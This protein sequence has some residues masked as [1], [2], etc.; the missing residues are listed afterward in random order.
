MAGSS[1]TLHYPT[2]DRSLARRLE[3]AEAL[4]TVGYVEAR[5]HLQPSCGATWIENSGVHAVFDGVTSPL[6]QTF[7]LGV[8][9]DTTEC[10]LDELERFFAERA[11]A[12]AHEVCAFASPG[13]WEDLSSRG[14]SPIETSV[15][16]VRPTVRPPVADSLGVAAHRIDPEDIPTWSLVMAR[17]LSGESASMVSA[18]RQLAPAMA[19]SE[20]AHCFLA[21]LEG[22]PIA[23]GM[24]SIK[25]GIAVLGGASTIPT[26][27]R[28]GAQ[29]ALLQV[30]LEHAAELGVELAMLVADPG[31]AS[32]R[33]AERK[34]FRPTYTR[35]KWIAR[36][37]LV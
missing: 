33:N 37:G 26:A 17:G 16:L 25:D 18:V 14:Y 31:S 4:A 32:Q 35:S 22:A 1:S 29:G 12:A 5:R 28:R 7:G 13:T 24:M 34:G 19:K 3:R 9:A 36:G 15:V 20:G 23:A 8:F 27:R 21:E 11:V 2:I 30:R 10:A 6:T